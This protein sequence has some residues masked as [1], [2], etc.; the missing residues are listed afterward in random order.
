MATIRM[1]YAT[2][3]KS[4]DGKYEVSMELSARK[5]HADTLGNEAEVKLQ[6]WIDVG[7]YAD[8]DEEELLAWKRVQLNDKEAVVT[9]LVDTIPAK[10]AIDPRRVL[11]ERITSDNVKPVELEE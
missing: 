11:I 9:M 4:T 5:L 7:V 8:D 2:A 3:N 10:A 6:E 1:E